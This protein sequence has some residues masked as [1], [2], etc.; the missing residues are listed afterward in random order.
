MSAQMSSLDLQRFEQRLRGRMDELRSEIG[1]ARER[2]SS[3]RYTQ[4]AGEAHDAGDDSVAN[5]TVDMTSADIRRDQ[6]EFKELDEA[7]GRISAGSYG[8][9]LRCGQPIE[10]AR[11]EAS[12]AAKRHVAC[13]EAHERESGSAPRT[14]KL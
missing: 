11:L 9:C 2:R 10:P 5:L 3:E 13:Q 14:P 6:E 4:L 8:I 1:E 7:L 12:P